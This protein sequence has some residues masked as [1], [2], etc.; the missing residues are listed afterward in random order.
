VSISI[1]WFNDSHTTILV[2]Y[3]SRF[4]WEEYDRMEQIVAGM[5]GECTTPVDILIDFRLSVP[6]LD[7]ARRLSRMALSSPFLH[8]PMS[9][10]II[11]CSPTHFMR[12]LLQTFDLLFNPQRGKLHYVASLDEGI[13]RLRDIRRADTP[14]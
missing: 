14:L 4:D 2:T 13:E 6:P 9:G 8:H 5:L 11:V 1:D 12:S 7:Y 10:H 3:V